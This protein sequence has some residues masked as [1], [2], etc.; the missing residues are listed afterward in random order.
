MKQK[1]RFHTWAEEMIDVEVLNVEP[2]HR[3]ITLNMEVVE[4]NLYAIK[5]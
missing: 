4:F 5:G 3:E 2:V 1:K